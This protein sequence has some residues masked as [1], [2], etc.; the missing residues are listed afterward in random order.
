[1]EDDRLCRIAETAIGEAIENAGLDPDTSGETALYMSSAIGP[2]STMEKAA[3]HAGTAPSG[4]WGAFSLGRLPAHLAR[5]TGLGGAYVLVPTGCTGGC[6]ALGYA[7]AAL[8]EFPGEADP[9]NLNIVGYSGGGGN[10][11]DIVGNDEL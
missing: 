8:R 2:M 7:L 9:G 6:D 5:R 10:A 11:I 1:M 3:A 4:A